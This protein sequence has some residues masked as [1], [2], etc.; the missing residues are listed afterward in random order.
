M[1][2]LNFV[3]SAVVVGLSV[4]ACS[5]PC[6]RFNKACDERKASDEVSGLCATLVEGI[7]RFGQRDQFC[8]LGLEALAAY[9]KDGVRGLRAFEEDDAVRARARALRGLPAQQLV[10]SPSPG[11][12]EFVVR[13]VIEAAMT[14]DFEEGWRK[15][16]P[17][18]HSEQLASPASEQTWKSMNFA[19]FKRTVRLLLPDES[20]PHFTRDHSETIEGGRHEYVRVYVVNKASDRPRPFHLMRDPAAGNEWRLNGSL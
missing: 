11:E 1:R 8:A 9:D 5:S 13:Q 10:E 12:P 20:K 16:R 3:V 6:E 19:A 14:A 4:A 18:L 7:D 15:F 17:W 2:V